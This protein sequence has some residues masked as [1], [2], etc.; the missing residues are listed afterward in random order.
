MANP[1]F[2][3]STSSNTITSNSAT[4][5]ITLPTFVTFLVSNVHSLVMTKLDSSSYIL[6]KSSVENVF[7]ASSLFDYLDGSVSCPNSTSN[8][9]SDSLFWQ[10]I[11]VVFCP[12]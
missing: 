10:A 6:W 5:S 9:S 1:N 2:S 4:N 11:M 7:R 12:A 3:N 8:D